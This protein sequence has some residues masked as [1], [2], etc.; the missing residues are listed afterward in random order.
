MSKPKVAVSDA[1]LEQLYR[2][3]RALI[4]PQLEDFGII[5]V[6][7]QAAGR[8]VIAFGQGGA[9]DTVIPMQSPGQH[10]PTGV[11][12]DQPSAASLA[13]AV[14][15]FLHIERQFESKAIRANAER[16]DVTEFVQGITRYVEECL[17]TR[18]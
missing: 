7:A 11:F 4:Y 12:F 17:D 14:E 1:E 16:F 9:T 3:C 18:S 6:E 10:E 2:D 15:Q 13:S 8:P 5:A